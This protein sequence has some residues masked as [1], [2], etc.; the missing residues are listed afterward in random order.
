VRHEDLGVATA[1]V[2]FFRQMGSM[3]GVAAFG[4]IFATH[5]RSSLE[6]HLPAA[7][8]RVDPTSLANSP[9][10]IRALPAGVRTI[11]IHGLAS[12]I[13]VVFLAAVP[14]LIIGFAASWLVRQIPLRDTV[15]VGA[16][17][18]DI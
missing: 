7:S 10:Q 15:H 9:A 3:F 16:S 18:P 2:N 17:T 6:K 13:H 1:G 8:R 11:V 4:A 14:V 5:L 12:S